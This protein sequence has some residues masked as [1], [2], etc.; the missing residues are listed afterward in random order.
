M[1]IKMH[2]L[3]EICIQQAAFLLRYGWIVFTSCVNIHLWIDFNKLSVENLYS[4]FMGLT[5]AQ[6]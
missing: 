6:I 1:T 5:V 2:D 4:A 3:L